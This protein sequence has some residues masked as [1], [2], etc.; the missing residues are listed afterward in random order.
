MMSTDVPDLVQL[1][2]TTKQDL[3]IGT[4]IL[5]DTLAQTSLLQVLNEG[6]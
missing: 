6:N 5:G 1:S 4:E 3:L 2:E